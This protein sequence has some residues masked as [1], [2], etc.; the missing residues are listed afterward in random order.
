MTRQ[1]IRLKKIKGRE[2][3]V[4]I[5]TYYFYSA[6]FGLTTSYY[7]NYTC[8]KFYYEQAKYSSY[9]YYNKEF[10]QHPYFY[11]SPVILII[12]IFGIIMTVCAAKTCTKYRYRRGV[13]MLRCKNC[14][15]QNACNERK[16]KYRRASLL[17]RKAWL[18]GIIGEGDDESYK[19]PKLGK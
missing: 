17:Y 7:S 3:C 2:A 10:K 19:L 8:L 9:S 13:P 16:L 4:G 11:L 18:S 6:Y 5:P 14:L 15:K 12:G 1:K